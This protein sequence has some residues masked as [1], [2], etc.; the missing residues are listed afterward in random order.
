MSVLVVKVANSG[1]LG[2]K[3]LRS[4]SADC[5]PAFPDSGAVVV[6]MGRPSSADVLGHSISPG[7]VGRRI[8]Q[9]SSGGRS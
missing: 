8:Q 1:G 5:N 6:E 4:W 7:R 2:S 9:F 3:L